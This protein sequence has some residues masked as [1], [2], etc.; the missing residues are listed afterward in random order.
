[1]DIS[2][3]QDTNTQWSVLIGD[4]LHARNNA[5]SVAHPNGWILTLG[6]RGKNDEMAEV[7][8]LFDP[9]SE[10]SFDTGLRFEKKNV[11]HAVMPVDSVSAVLRIWGGIYD[12]LNVKTTLY[13]EMQYIIMSTYDAIDPT[14]TPTFAPSVSPT[15]PTRD[16]TSDPTSDPTT[17]PSHDPTTLEPTTRVP[18]SEPTTQ[19][20]T[21][22]STS[23]SS[24]NLVLGD[25]PT[26]EPT[27][28]P[29]EQ[30]ALGE[31]EVNVESL[32][33]T[34]GSVAEEAPDNPLIDIFEA[35]AWHIVIIVVVFLTLCFC[36]CA[37]AIKKRYD[38]KTKLAAGAVNRTSTIEPQHQG[39]TDAVEMTKVKAAAAGGVLQAKRRSMDVM[40]EGLRRMTT[41]GK[42]VSAGNVVMSDE[43]NSSDSASFQ[44]K[45]FL[46]ANWNFH[47]A[48]PRTDKP[49]PMH[50]R[51][52]SEMLYE[53]GAEPVTMGSPSMSR[54]K[55]NDSE[56]M[57]V[58]KQ[59][60]ST[61][62]TLRTRHEDRQRG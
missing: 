19:P 56:A 4:L 58:L 1:M 43:E 59:Q 44:T 48:D 28:R 55:S 14:P 51:V 12:P 49:Q 2:D 54:I 16:P 34:S 24:Q 47:G 32:E 37:Y 33:T 41:P 42:A 61:V 17:Q 22:P 39:D 6:G 62:K 29:T 50:N 5:V 15:F 45:G 26:K 13:A 21:S 52:G 53:A 27:T 23:P 20:S 3:A 9:V 10:N 7:I 31:G 46:E 57:Y 38:F 8:E 40:E 36:T 60:R 35:D 30:R 18:S 25:G 11:Y